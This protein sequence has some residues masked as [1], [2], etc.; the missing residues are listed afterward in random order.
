MKGAGEMPQQFQALAAFT[1][2]LDLIHI[3][4][5]TTVGNSS[6]KGS[7]TSVLWEHLHSCTQTHMQTHIHN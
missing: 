5:L 2:D 3:R 1:K 6:S 4:H 7:N